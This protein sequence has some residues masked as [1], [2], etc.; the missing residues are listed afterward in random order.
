MFL[1]IFYCDGIFGCYKS[2]PLKKNLVPRFGEIGKE[3]KG[4]LL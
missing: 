4:T 2:A 1:A 3:T